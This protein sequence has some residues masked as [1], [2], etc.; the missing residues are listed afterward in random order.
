M[1]DQP[2]AEAASYTTRNKHER[3]KSMPS[4][5]FELPDS[6]TVETEDLRLRP[7]A[8]EIGFILR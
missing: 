8:T 4:A 5:G 2:V 1:R 6:S 3:P 7:R